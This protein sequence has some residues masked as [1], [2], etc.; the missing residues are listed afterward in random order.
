MHMLSHTGTYAAETP[1][2]LEEVRRNLSSSRWESLSGDTSRFTT[3]P[4]LVAEKWYLLESMFHRNV[5]RESHISCLGEWSAVVGTSPYSVHDLPVQDYHVGCFAELAGFFGLGTYSTFEGYIGEARLGTTRRGSDLFFNDFSSG[6]FTGWSGHTGD[7]FL[8][9]ITAGWGCK[10]V[11]NPG[12]DR[13]NPM[14]GVE[15]VRSA[16]FHIPLANVGGPL[17]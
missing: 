3:T 5:K 7:H 1:T 8:S 9:G 10:V 6:D 2:P 4:P 15:G 13:Y 17:L 16:P 14:C 12:Y 11:A